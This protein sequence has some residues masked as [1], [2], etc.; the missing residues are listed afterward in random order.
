MPADS[1]VDEAMSPDLYL[2]ATQSAEYI[3]QRIPADL[4]TPSVGIICG[5][6]LGGLADVVLPSHRAGINYRDIPHFPKSTG[7][8][9][10]TC[11][12]SKDCHVDVEQ[13]KGMLAGLFSAFS[14]KTHLLSSLWLE[15]HSQCRHSY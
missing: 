11:H 2:R 7:T 8:C 9:C 3:K 5:S 1:T 13:Y 10:Q 4:R 14:Q 12:F 15:E 6:G